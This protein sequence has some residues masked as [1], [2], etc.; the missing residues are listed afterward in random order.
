MGGE[1]RQKTQMHK[2][3]L[4]VNRLYLCCHSCVST[5]EIHL[6]RAKTEIISA[7]ASQPSTPLEYVH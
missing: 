3:E 5:E 2:V 7:F 6:F 1:Y 4:F